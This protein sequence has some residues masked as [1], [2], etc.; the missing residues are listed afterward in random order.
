MIKQSEV[1]PNMKTINSDSIKVEEKRIRS[2]LDDDDPCKALHAGWPVR[3]FPGVNVRGAWEYT[4][5]AGSRVMVLDTSFRAEGYNFPL[6]RI[7]GS[8][9]LFQ[10]HV[11]GH[12]SDV[13]AVMATNGTRESEYGTIPDASFI[14]RSITSHRETEIIRH[15]EEALAKGGQVV[16]MSIVYQPDALFKPGDNYLT[17]EGQP[18]GCTELSQTVINRLIERGVSVVTAAGNHQRALSDHYPLPDLCAGVVSVA[19]S[20]ADG[21]LAGYSN[22][23]PGVDIIAPGA[24]V[25]SYYPGDIRRDERELAQCSIGTSFASPHVA[26]AIG[27]MLS[28]DGGLS[29][30][31]RLDYL[32]HS[33]YKDETLCTAELCGSGFLD[34]EALVLQV[35]S[36]IETGACEG[37]YYSKL[38]LPER[39]DTSSSQTYSRN[40]W[41]PQGKT[42]LFE[43]D[44]KNN[45]DGLRLH[46]QELEVATG[47][48]ETS[49]L[50]PW[51]DSEELIANL[52]FDQGRFCRLINHSE[53]GKTYR[54][55]LTSG[56]SSGSGSGSGFNNSE[57]YLLPP[58]HQALVS[59]H[60]TPIHFD[61]NHPFYQAVIGSKGGLGWS[62]WRRHRFID[63]QRAQE[64]H[65]YSQSPDTLVLT[66]PDSGNELTPCLV[67]EGRPYWYGSSKKQRVWIATTSEFSFGLVNAEQRCQVGGRK[68]VLSASYETMMSLSPQA[69]SPH[70][71]AVSASISVSDYQKLHRQSIGYVNEEGLQAMCISRS[72]NGSFVIGVA[73]ADQPVCRY[74]TY[75]SDS[76]A[77]SDTNEIMPF[78]LVSQH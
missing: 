70:L 7:D 45:P 71:M 69:G 64:E 30:Q 24:R 29:N 16:N 43:F 18:S 20:S 44:E 13:L 35:R 5:G 77:H 31:Q 56:P 28:I 65:I 68:E 26:G 33:A 42:V 22:F 78:S 73:D 61:D 8:E 23:G 74:K 76:P 46:V 19:A 50:Q 21:R 75:R 60:S 47:A 66:V 39:E 25:F 38:S 41:V 58:L 72:D 40:I 55:L 63:K 14:A 53:G 54:V 48:P 37:G 34:L 15:L 2:L 49:S 57:S 51:D 62:R 59:I 52:C 1:V 10:E 6:H 17:L 12:G 36:A 67:S 32:Y 4:R 11:G 9:H 3:G 27:M